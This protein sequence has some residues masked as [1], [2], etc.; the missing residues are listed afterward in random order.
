MAVEVKLSGALFTGQAT[1]V[2]EAGL[3]ESLDVVA[4]QGLADVHHHLD[5]VIQNPTPYYET[6]IVVDRQVNDRVIHDRGIIYGP[7]LEGVGSRNKTTRFKGYHTFRTVAQE[8]E[9]KAAGLVEPILERH[10]GRL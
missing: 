9:R 10:L 3:Q 4:Q 6:Q 5:R 8:L 1:A 7:W 2:V